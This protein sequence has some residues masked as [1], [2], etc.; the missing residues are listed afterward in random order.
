M[1]P[2]A[3][4]IRKGGCIAGVA[5]QVGF[6]LQAHYCGQVGLEPDAVAYEL[7]QLLIH[8]CLLLLEALSRGCMHAHHSLA[9]E[10][11]CCSSSTTAS[12]KV[13]HEAKHSGQQLKAAE[14]MPRNLHM[15]SI[16][17][18]LPYVSLKRP[19]IAVDFSAPII[20][21][22]MLLGLQN[23]A[24]ACKTAQCIRRSAY[25]PACSPCAACGGWWPRCSPRSWRG[26][27]PPSAWPAAS[28]SSAPA[29]LP[30]ASCC[31]P[32]G[33]P[34]PASSCESAKAHGHQRFC[35]P[36]GNGPLPTGGLAERLGICAVLLSL[37]SMLCLVKVYLQLGMHLLI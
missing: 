2:A 4:D 13:L 20:V 9:A 10:E 6:L 5:H 24:V 25:Q 14:S 23:P 15:M 26:R 27:Q 35:R 34:A 31:R 33:A 7:R 8:Q 11:K 32:P 12:A 28:R 17:G 30:C 3:L 19:H 22:S 36:H 21:L 37:L 29:G 16:I 18:L 1:D